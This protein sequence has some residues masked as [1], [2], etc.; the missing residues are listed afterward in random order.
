MD[1]S[2]GVATS[3]LNN[4]AQRLL[5]R[6]PPGWG[7]YGNEGPQQSQRQSPPLPAETVCLL[8][9]GKGAASLA[10]GR[11]SSGLWRSSA[12]WYIGLVTKRLVGEPEE[13]I[14]AE[15]GPG[16][17]GGG[18]YCPPHLWVPRANTAPQADREGLKASLLCFEDKA[19]FEGKTNITLVLSLVWGLLDNFKNLGE[20]LQTLHPLKMLAFYRRTS[21]PT[22]LLTP[23]FTSLQWLPCHSE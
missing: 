8:R 14:S 5:R 1:P 2:D 18:G 17:P 6:P 20:A 9:C 4:G 3:C 13:P 16:V 11:T 12:A 15:R 21:Q 7:H 23:R 10:W 22:S 19:R